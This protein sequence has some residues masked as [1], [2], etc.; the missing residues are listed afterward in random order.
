MQTAVTPSLEPPSPWDVPAPVLFNTWKHHAGVLRQRIAE[1]VRRGPLSLPTLAHE[2][3][4]IG[5]KLIGD[6]LSGFSS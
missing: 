2:L 3:V 1:Y 5:A 4:V 6:A